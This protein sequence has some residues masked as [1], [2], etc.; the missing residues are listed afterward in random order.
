MN[1]TKIFAIS[2]AMF[3]MFAIMSLSGCGKDETS[4][5]QPEVQAAI[6][7]L[8]EIASSPDRRALIGRS[9]Q[10]TNAV[11]R[12]VVGNYVFWAGDERNQIPVVRMD[13]MLGPVTEHVRE[14]S[15]V[16]IIGTVRLVETVAESDPMWETVN[17]NEKTEVKGA[18]VY[19]A[20]DKIEVIS[21]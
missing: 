1:H 20:G 5:N 16:K 14:G 9:V 18:V 10:T 3:A 19:V 21:E 15:I 12:G 4:A 6:T 13:K 2:L 8:N 7:D 11:V 17:E